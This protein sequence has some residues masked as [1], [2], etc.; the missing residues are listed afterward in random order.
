MGE[1]WGEQNGRKF[2]QAV[3]RVSDALQAPH[4]LVR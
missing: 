4:L 2:N 3:K 1:I